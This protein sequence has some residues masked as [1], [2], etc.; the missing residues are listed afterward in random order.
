MCVKSTGYLSQAFI[1]YLL[2]MK[3]SITLVNKEFLMKSAFIS[4]VQTSLSNALSSITLSIADKVERKSPVSK[5]SVFGSV[6]K[7]ELIKRILF[8]VVDIII[9]WILQCAGETYFTCCCISPE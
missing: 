6:G 8:H 7:Y 2:L 9:A 3:S 1:R 5:F 4:L